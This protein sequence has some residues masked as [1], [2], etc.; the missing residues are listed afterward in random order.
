MYVDVR[1][2]SPDDCISLLLLGAGVPIT[3]PRF[4]SAGH[5]DDTRNALLYITHLYPK[6]P[7]LALGFSLGSNVITRYLGEEKE[8]ARFHAACALACV[9]RESNIVRYAP[10]IRYVRNALALGLGRQ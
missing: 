7:L 8:N 6:A 9:S 3:S 1:Q 4:Y 10:L 5:T 2:Y